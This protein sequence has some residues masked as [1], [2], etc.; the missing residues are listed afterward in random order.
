MVKVFLWK[1][2]GVMC[3][4]PPFSFFLVLGFSTVWSKPR[5]TS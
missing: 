4:Q 1:L 5:Y 3:L 2:Y